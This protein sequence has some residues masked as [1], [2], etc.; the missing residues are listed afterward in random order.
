MKVQF[1]ASVHVIDHTCDVIRPVPIK[2]IKIYLLEKTNF[3]N[4]PFEY[5]VK[6][7]NDVECYY[8]HFSNVEL[9]EEHVD[10]LYVVLN[11]NVFSMEVKVMM[12]MNHLLFRLKKKKKHQIKGRPYNN[13]KRR[14]SGLAWLDR[15]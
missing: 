4:L 6:F 7:L 10:E 9:T 8:W 13:R 14:R 12:M 1:Q 2:I 11:R 3:I 5:V 15:R